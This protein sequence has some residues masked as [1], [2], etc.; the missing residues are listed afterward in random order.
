MDYVNLGKTGLKVS[1][2]CL[3]CMSYGAPAAG[4]VKPGSHA[5]ALNEAGSE[6][7]FRQA[8]ELGI[9]FFDTANVYSGGA[10]RRCSAD[11]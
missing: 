11:S 8:I 6:P 5:W 3:G 10:V 7:F 2:I 4:K 1:R 9:N